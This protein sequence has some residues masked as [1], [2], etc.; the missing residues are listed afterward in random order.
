MTATSDNKL[1]I[2]TAN[3]QITP[4]LIINTIRS[5]GLLLDSMTEGFEIWCFDGMDWTPVIKNDIGL[6]SNGLDNTKNLGARSM[7]EYPLNSGNIVIGTF[8]MINP[9]PLIS[10]EGCELWMRSSY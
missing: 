8:K 10:W 1:W 7:I 9:N 4:S 5:N 3:V 6:K 2:G